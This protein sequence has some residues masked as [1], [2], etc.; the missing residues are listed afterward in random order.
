MSERPGG[1]YPVEQRLPGG[2]PGGEAPGRP[3]AIRE[4]RE[5]REQ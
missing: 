4:G 3:R 5:E 2:R 1:G